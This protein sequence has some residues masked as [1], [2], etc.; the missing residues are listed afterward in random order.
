MWF[1]KHNDIFLVKQ[2]LQCNLVFG[3]LVYFLKHRT[4]NNLLFFWIAYICLVISYL[5]YLSNIFFFKLYFYLHF[6]IVKDI[7]VFTKILVRSYKLK[8]VNSDSQVLRYRNRKNK[9]FPKFI[10][11]NRDELF[12]NNIIIYGISE[13]LKM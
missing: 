3:I 2:K 5:K 7:N 6:T 1:M 4:Y 8:G 9:T 13:T 11:M 12:K 10:L